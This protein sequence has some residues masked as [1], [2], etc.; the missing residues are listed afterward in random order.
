MQISRLAPVLI[1]ALLPVASA[2][3]CTESTMVAAS[4]T[5]IKEFT[6]ISEAIDELTQDIMPIDIDTSAKRLMRRQEDSN[7]Y[8]PANC[9]SKFFSPTVH[10]TT[11]DHR[12]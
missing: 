10:Q 12:C 6:K 9:M 4:E 8:V 5:S 11:E 2:V 1:A 3:L 7:I